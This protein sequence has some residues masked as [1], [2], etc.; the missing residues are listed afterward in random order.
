VSIVH[1]V[2]CY[3]LTKG[4]V[5]EVAP[6]KVGDDKP[7]WIRAEITLDVS[8]LSESVR[9]EW[10]S[11]RTDDVVFLMAVKAVDEAM[12]LAN[13]NS[14]IQSSEMLGLRHLRAAEIVQVLDENGKPL[15]NTQNEHAGSRGQFSRNHMRRLHVKLDS[16]MYRVGTPPGRPN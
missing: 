15:R 7:A 5:L 9:R 2:L 6:P 4:S 10:E 14:S 13:G 8:R 12:P 3:L 1:E 16:S 11:L